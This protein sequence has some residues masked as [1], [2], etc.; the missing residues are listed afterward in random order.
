MNRLDFEFGSPNLRL[1]KSN[2]NHP[3]TRSTTRDSPKSTPKIPKQK[4]MKIGSFATNL[5][6]LAAATAARTNA[7]LVETGDILEGYPVIENFDTASL[8]DG[9]PG[10]Y[11]YWFRG[12]EDAG[13]LCFAFAV[14]VDCH[15][16][17][18]RIQCKLTR[19]IKLII[20]RCCCATCCCSRRCLSYSCHGQD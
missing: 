20:N 7:V 19:K 18:N 15:A 5:F 17:A 2:W 6:L 13:K 8:T 12:A 4:T 14:A 11:K 9:E 10:T 3:K 16:I 1:I